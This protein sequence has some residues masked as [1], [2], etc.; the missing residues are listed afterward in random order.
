MTKRIFTATVCALILIS[1]YSGFGQDVYFPAGEASIGNSQNSNIGIGTNSTP[2][3]KL[4]VAGNIQIGSPEPGSA[5][6]YEINMPG[7]SAGVNGG[8]GRNLVIIP[9]S[10]DNAAHVTGGILYLRAGRPTAPSNNFGKVVIADEGGRV[11]VGTSNP[12]WPLDVNGQISVRGQAFVDA[13]STTISIGDLAGGDGLRSTLMFHTSDQARMTLNGSGNLGI[14][15]SD[16]DERLTVKGKI[17]T[18]EVRVDTDARVFPDYVF[19]SDYHLITLE[20]LEAYVKANKHLPEVPTGKEV[21]AEG[22]HL[23][24]M[25]LILL[26]KVEELTLHLIEANKRIKKLESRTSDH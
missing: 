7:G 12:A 2:S 13:T 20:E 8:Q 10:S 17:H 9:G 25:N 16:P 23:K 4:H 1:H 18:S 6:T 5:G 14:G 11:G 3:E 22:M 19:E 24:E 21:E 26:R 15:T